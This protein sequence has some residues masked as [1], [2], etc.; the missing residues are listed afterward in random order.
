[1]NASVDLTL[2]DQFTEPEEMAGLFLVDENSREFRATK[3]RISGEL[4]FSPPSVDFRGK[5][6]KEDDFS[7]YTY[8]YRPATD[9]AGPLRILVNDDY[10]YFQVGPSTEG[11]YL[12]FFFSAIRKNSSE[13]G[14][15]LC[16]A[17]APDD[18]VHWVRFDNFR[19]TKTR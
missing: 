2:I 12:N 14:F 17:G 18:A 13:R 5:A 6:G 4:F 7:Q 8:T 3:Q 11:K 9:K 19:V 15:A 10:A 16:A 1:V